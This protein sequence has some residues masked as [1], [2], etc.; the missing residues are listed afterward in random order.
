MG[1]RGYPGFSNEALDLSLISTLIS[2]GRWNRTFT[3]YLVYLLKPSI[4]GDRW[5][6]ST[7]PPSGPI[8]ARFRIA[9]CQWNRC[10]IEYLLRNSG[11]HKR[12]FVSC[13]T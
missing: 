2:S 4:R 5:G 13:A 6:G 12:M 10:Q 3:V 1:A 7:I 11:S 8:V 9:R